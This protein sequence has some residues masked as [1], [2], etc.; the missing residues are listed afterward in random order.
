MADEMDD[1]SGPFKPDLRLE[2]FSKEALVTLCREFMLA[3]HLLDRAIMP[4]ILQLLIQHG[5][6][7]RWDAIPYPRVGFEDPLERLDDD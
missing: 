4:A 2:D 6:R 1:Y 3:A 5:H 7:V